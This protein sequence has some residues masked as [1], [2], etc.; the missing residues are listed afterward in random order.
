M[1]K[2]R[3]KRAW[4]IRPEV[5]P[6][7]RT[8]TKHRR[9]ID[10]CFATL[11]CG[12]ACAPA[13]A[14][15]DNRALEE[16]IVTGTRLSVSQSAS[17]APVTVLHHRDVERGGA[18]SVAKLVRAL[19]MNTG[20]PVNTNL[21]NGGDGSARVDLRGLGTERTIVLLNGRRLPNGGVGGDASVDLNMLPVA[22]LER[23]E[24]LASGASAVYGA[25]A[26]GGVVNVITRRAFEGLQVAAARTI[27]ERGDGEILHGHALAGITV[28]EGNWS[29]GLDYTR[30]AGVKLDRRAYSAVPLSI[31]DANGTRQF[32]G[33]G[34]IAEGRFG[35]PRGNA[36]G[37]APG[38][39]TRVNGAQGRTAADYRLFEETDRFNF[40]P[41]TYS[42]TPNER[43]SFWLAGFQPLSQDAQF[44]FE[45]LLHHRESEQ[46]LAPSPFFAQ[47]GD[48]P[49]LEDGTPGI[50]A[51]NYYNPFG[52]DIRSLGRR[53]VEQPTRGFTQDLDMWRVL[54]GIE[55]TM[56]DWTWRLAYARSES[57]TE[58]VESG[59]LLRT[60]LVP[61]LGPSGPDDSGRIVCGARDPATGRVPSA[62]II[63]DCVPLNLFGGAGTIT[64]E[65]LDYLSAPLVNSGT[66]EQELAE[67]VLSGQ[68]GQLFGQDLQW[69]LGAEYRRESGSL[70]GDPLGS[71][72]VASGLT[73]DLPVGSFDAREVFAELQLPL[74]RDRAWA[75]ELALNLGV[76]WSDFSSF[77]ENTAWRTGLRWQVTS[78][79][80]LR[81]N[82][83]DVFRAPSLFELYQ[84]L[85]TVIDVGSDPCGN[86]PTPEQQVNCGANG[87]PG[88]AYVEQDDLIP[89][90]VGGN[91]ELSPEKGRSLGA[92]V[93]W[94]PPWMQGLSL[95][96]DYF[97]IELDDFIGH[98]TLDEA[99]Q[100]CADH[101]DETVCGTISRFADGSVSRVDL[102]GR[103]FGTLE[104]SGFDLA[105]ELR[106][107]TRAGDIDTRIV[108]T[109]LDEWDEQPFPGGE[110]FERAGE[111]RTFNGLPRVL[112]RWRAWGYF[113]WNRGPWRA[114]YAAEYIG[115]F[116]ECGDGG[117][118]LDDSECRRVGS[119]IV[120]DIEGGY[121]HASGL[122][123]RAAIT[124][125]TDRDPPFVNNGSEA[126]TD[127]TTYR[128][129]G[130]T[131][132]LELSC[133]FR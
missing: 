53:F 16:I 72:G 109:Y 46:E 76:R 67:G 45:A 47:F 31:V 43:G 19:P 54:A 107:A 80:A 10:G 99:L 122:A 108:A 37:L 39:Y 11:L 95:S 96:V 13:S 17:I 104:T 110:V 60:R 85:Q 131:Y 1:V 100:Q 98:A 115:S 55:G 128:L 48:G 93:I 68:W 57:D 121:E 63:P 92:G 36:L 130:R 71:Q 106:T 52:L 59:L 30:Q 105:V 70:V 61:A 23:I 78:Q 89:T 123:L 112:P 18:D 90:L 6:M 125:V 114:S 132:Y 22:W 15:P 82:Y 88:G 32:A 62:N 5:S 49:T 73:Q 102:T 8:D 29:L 25:D 75:R 127:P 118:F 119:M 129:L 101:G 35:V 2:A 77:D 28:L 41:Y 51:T 116:E 81:A 91:P 126:N 44:L 38:S 124:N 69:A 27:T 86:E 33:S 21:N 4:S 20:S 40:A 94:T 87:V 65:Q 9:V 3:M 133:S 97:D 111:L 50:P 113:D 120:H 26:V 58:S 84:S 103:N 79:I 66:N 74:V 117:Q 12:S 7:G 64:Q 42:Q 24:V 34:A 83:S 14:A 56:R